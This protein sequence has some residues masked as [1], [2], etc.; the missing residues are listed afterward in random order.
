ME[1]RNSYLRIRNYTGALGCLLPALSIIGACFGPNKMYPDWWTSISITYY[2]SPVLVA[3]LSAVSLFLI[4]YRGYNGWDTAVNTTAGIAG[5]FVVCFPCEASWVS[6]DTRVG[7]FWLPVDITRWFHYCSAFILFLMLALNSICL[8]SKGTN[9]K[10][11]II[12]KVCGYVILA[13]LLFFGLNALFF[14]LKWTIIV[15]ETIMLLAFGF[16][17]LVKGHLF[18]RFFKK[19]EVKSN[20]EV[21]EVKKEESQTLMNLM[22]KYLSEFAK[23]EKI[24]VKDDGLFGYEWLDSY[25]KEENRWPYF[26]KIDGKL[27][28]FVLV[29]DY[30]EVPEEST[31]FTLSEFFIMP[32]YR[33]IG[34]GHQAFLK[35]MDKHHGKWQLKLHPKNE[36]SVLFWN[37]VIDEYTSGRFR[38][39]EAY[40][41]KEVNYPDGTPADVY[42]FEN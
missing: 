6:M 36:A 15:N 31:D 42:F 21:V 24:D 1:K 37:Q 39:V 32:K 26:V 12:Y 9:K 19:E 18:D 17:W 30:P 22:E 41:N 33:N 2:S 5:L 11:N 35:V 16:S 3:V 23:W 28:G 40:P 29:C 8:F 25:F 20:L 4:L 14:K 13:D 27:A 38:L 10:K 7:L 34:Y